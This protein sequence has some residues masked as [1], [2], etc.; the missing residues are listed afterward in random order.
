MGTFS[1]RGV[2]KTYGTS[3]VLADVTCDI[4]HGHVHGLIGPNGAGKTTLLRALAGQVPVEGEV[5]MDGEPVRDNQPVLDRIILAGADVPYPGQM[6]VGTLLDLGAARWA[7]WDGDYAHR[8]QRLF[9]LDPAARFD[10]LPRG[11]KTLVGVVLGLAA[12]AEVTLLDEPYLG[13]DVQNRDILYR[14]LLEEVSRDTAAARTFVISTH[15]VEDVWLLLDSVI[16]IDDGRTS[17]AVDVDDLLSSTVVATGTAGAVDGLLKGVS[18]P[19]LRDEAVAGS[20]RVVLDLGSG[21]PDVF[22]A[23]D[24]LDVRVDYADLPETVLVRGRRNE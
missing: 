18:C 8:L 13:L 20:R 1:L 10:D 17:G 4:P 14:E 5:T 16:L 19:V 11:R 9:R 3:P 22:R 6:K 2:R 21:V 15:H 7:H 23:A 24:G 12:R